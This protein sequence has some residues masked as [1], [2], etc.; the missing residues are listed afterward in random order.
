[1]QVQGGHTATLSRS[2]AHLSRSSEHGFV[3]ILVLK[4]TA[5]FSVILILRLDLGHGLTLIFAASLPLSRHPSIPIPGQPPASIARGRVTTAVGCSRTAV[6]AGP[7]LPVEQI[8]Q[9]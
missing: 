8:L 1:M 9:R 4:T 3:L 2:I 7:H 5:A 6:G